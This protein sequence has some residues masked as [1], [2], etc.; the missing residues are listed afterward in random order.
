MRRRCCRAPL[1][2]ARLT[3]RPGS[4]ESGRRGGRGAGPKRRWLVVVVRETRFALAPGAPNTVISRRNRFC[5]PHRSLALATG[6]SARSKRSRSAARSSTSSRCARAGSC[7]SLTT[8]AAPRRSPQPASQRTRIG[9]DQATPSEARSRAQVEAFHPA[10][11]DAICVRAGNGRS[12][13]A[14]QAVREAA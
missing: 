11:A 14:G 4:K 8:G 5:A 10:Y 6:A 1:F 12:L 3:R 7:A 9:T 13:A 2:V